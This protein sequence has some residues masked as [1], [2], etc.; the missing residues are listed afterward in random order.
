MSSLNQD[1][2]KSHA[3]AS[4]LHIDSGCMFV[5][6]ADVAQVPKAPGL[7]KIKVP[8]VNLEKSSSTV[9]WSSVTQYL[10]EGTMKVESRAFNIADIA[11]VDRQPQHEDDSA[12]EGNQF[13]HGMPPDSRSYGQIPFYLTVG[14]PFF[15]CFM[16]LPHHGVTLMV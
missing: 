16:V 2:T 8:E 5:L 1:V 4:R 6:F 12:G 13:Q 14:I 10:G 15:K 9:E 7:L 11:S 3:S